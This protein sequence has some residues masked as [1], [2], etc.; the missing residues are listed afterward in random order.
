VSAASPGGPVAAPSD[1]VLT[2]WSYLAAGSTPT[3][4]LKVVRP[5]GAGSFTAVADSSVETASPNVLNTF[6]TRIPVRAGDKI[7]LVMPAGGPCL[8]GAP[9]GWT[10]TSAASDDPPGTTSSYIG[11]GSG[12][13][14]ISAALE[15]DADGDG[16][17]DETQDGCPSD[18][19]LHEQ[20]CDRVAPESTITAGP[21]N[22]TRKKRATFEFSAV[23]ARAVTG[24]A[25]SLDDGSFAS[26][27]SPY[28][29]KVKKGKHTFSVRATDDAGNVEGAPAADSWKVRRKKQK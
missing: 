17:G 3:V 23:D 20:P 9:P 27:T 19:S 12:H 7:A 21:P 5:A 4:K 22:R 29:V 15:A 26:C 18:S 10:F 8:T 28:T 1:G 2:A 6:A 14:D 13:I 24:L 11:P 16:F 25:C